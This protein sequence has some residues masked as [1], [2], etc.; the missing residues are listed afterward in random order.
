MVNPDTEPTIYTLFG[1]R[2]FMFF[3]SN[4][5]DF[6]LLKKFNVTGF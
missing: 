4:I 3:D 5:T 1:V 2:N 6:P